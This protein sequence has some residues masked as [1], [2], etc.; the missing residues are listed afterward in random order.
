[1]CTPVRGPVPRGRAVRAPLLAVLVPA[2]IAGGCGH[3]PTSGY[4]AETSMYAGAPRQT[5]AAVPIPVEME[6]DGR[7]AQLPPR[8]GVRN[9][10]DDPR[11]PWSPNYGGPAVVKSTTKPVP[12]AVARRVAWAAD[13]D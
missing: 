11:E 1:M 2:L 4:Y 9:V 13:P 6:D 10:P 3:A 8:A 12:V 5:E 7:P